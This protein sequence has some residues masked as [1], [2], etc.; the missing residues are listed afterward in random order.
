LARLFSYF[1]ILLPAVLA[2]LYV[3]SFGVSVIV[4]D[5]F[6]IV[7]L[8]SRLAAGNLG[9]EH[10]FALHNEHRILFPRLV[11]LSLGELTDFKNLAEMYAIQACLLATMAVFLLAFRRNSGLP[12]VLFVPVAFLVFSLRQFENMLWGF[13]LTFVFAQVFSVAALYSL[14]LATEG[15]RPAITLPLAVASAFVA[16]FSSLPGLM[17]WPAGACLVL[18]SRA[19]NRVRLAAAWLVCGVASWALYF[20]DYETRPQAPPFLGYIVGNPVETALYFPTSLGASLMWHRPLALVAGAGILF[21]FAVA[22]WFSHR[23]GTLR[24]NAFWIGVVLFSLGVL[25]VITAGRASLGPQSAM[26]PRYS[27]FS[28]LAVIGVYVM[29]MKLVLDA[30]NLRDSATRLL[31]PLTAAFLV[32]LALIIPATYLGGYLVG[33]RNEA[34]MTQAAEA[35]RNAEAAPDVRLETLLRQPPDFIRQNAEILDRLDYNVFAEDP[36]D[37]EMDE[38]A[39]SAPSVSPAGG[40]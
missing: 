38:A 39:S 8:F 28:L 33:A 19:V 24:E 36:P 13:Q 18:V 12:M 2:F 34:T 14:Y 32:A 35:L 31:T 27:S 29:L 23:R 22:V 30:T 4:G 10:L 7:A 3:R 40:T 5:Q 9:L 6:R 25:A 21:L 16:T 37:E 15:K 20:F 26:A 11:M 17:V 1:L